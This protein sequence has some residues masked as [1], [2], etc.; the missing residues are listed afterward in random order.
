M[1]RILEQ[2]PITF[3]IIV[4]CV[5]TGFIFYADISTEIDMQQYVITS[6]YFENIITTE[7][8]DGYIS[9]FEYEKLSRKFKRTYIKPR[10]VEK[11]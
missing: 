7:L 3:S 10:K 11:E 6:T 2:Y 1:I 9:K 4:I 8:D 5:L